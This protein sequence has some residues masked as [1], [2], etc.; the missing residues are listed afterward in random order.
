MIRETDFVRALGL[1]VLLPGKSGWL[2]ILSSDI[3]RPGLPLSGYYDHFSYRRPQVF[4]NAE[5]AYVDSLPDEVLRE[6]LKAFFS[7]DIPCVIMTHGMDSNATL[8]ETARMG[9]VPVYASHQ[10]AT[11][12]VVRLINYLNNTL[13]P[14]V[15]QHGVLI[16]VFGSGILITGDSGVGK[17]E[18]ALELIKRG[19]RLVA[20][21]VVEIKRVTRDRLIG[22][23]PEMI[24]HFMEIRGVG[25]IDIATMYGIGAVIDSKSIDLVVHF[26]LWK[27]DVE[28]DRLGLDD[29]YAEILDVRVPK[30]LIPIRPGRNLAVVLEVAARNFRLKQSGFNAAKSLDDRLRE[31][32][33]RAAV[34]EG[35]DDE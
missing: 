2:D 32:A 5:Q 6:R 30:L 20:D 16:D 35:E 9:G 14:R 19:H 15:T 31:R 23:A 4:G 24:K 18:T 26:E 10:E 1:T 25:I 22:E 29:Q 3:N 34:A 11:L 33:E 17:S 21:D 8:L 28:Y 12:F 13:A 27:S 7:F